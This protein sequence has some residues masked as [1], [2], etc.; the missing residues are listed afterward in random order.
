MEYQEGIMDFEP[1]K[2]WLVGYDKY[3]FTTQYEKGKP[4]QAQLIYVKPK[5]QVRE[6]FISSKMLTFEK[7]KDKK[8]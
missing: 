2:K 5:M 7:S 4:T 1:T 8:W 3:L 6:Q